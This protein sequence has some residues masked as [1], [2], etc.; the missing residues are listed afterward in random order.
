[1]S[2]REGDA[3]PLRYDI[4]T[5]LR[6]VETRRSEDCG[7]KAALAAS[8]FRTSG[9]KNRRT[10]P[11]RSAMLSAFKKSSRPRFFVIDLQQERFE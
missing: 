1:M 3:A 9:A 10:P 2:K 11:M 6:K 7:T 4:A 8:K 5:D